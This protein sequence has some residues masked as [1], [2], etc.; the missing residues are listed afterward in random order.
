MKTALFQDLGLNENILQAIQKKGFT[1]AT[2]VQSKSIPAVLETDSDL[3]VQAQTGTGK[4]AAFGLP[5]LQLLNPSLKSVQAI[6]LTPTRELALQVSN[7]LNSFLHDKQFNIHSVYGGQSIDIQIRALKKGVDIVV[8]TPGRVID[9]IKRKTL[10]LNKINFLILDEADEMLNMGFLDDLETIMSSTPEEKRTFMFSATMP[11]AIKK[12]AESYMQESQ[13][14]K[15]EKKQLTTDLTKQIYYEVKMTYKFEALCRIIDI[16]DKFYGMVFCKTKADVDT[17][18]HHLIDRGYNAEAI[19]GDIGQIQREKTLKRFRDKI[20]NILVATDVAARGIDVNDLTHVVN[21]ALP[22]ETESYVHRIGRTGRAGKKGVAISLVSP[23]E[24]RK[25]GSIKKHTNTDIEKA[26]IPE[27]K[28]II[29]KKKQQIEDKITSNDMS[30]VHEVYYKWAVEL[31]ENYNPI[32]VL[33]STMQLGFSNALNPD[34]Y[35]EIKSSP[36]SRDKKDGRESR[37]RD[38]KGG[39]RLFIALG[40]K[41]N[42]TKIKL[43]DLL[44]SKSNVQKKYM[45]D[46]EIKDSFS[47]ITVPDNKV[48]TII[49]AFHKKRSKPLIT[50]ANETKEE[51]G[52]SR[53]K[54]K[55]KR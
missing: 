53:S 1:E 39:V 45:D 49:N 42:F 5:L 17:V 20:I 24:T 32:E 19:H 47:F 33:A 36:S 31:L 12:L 18:I 13:H 54:R 28:D 35:A 10:K 30:Q 15:I 40:K 11:S 43:L 22:Q 7:E 9:H 27:I 26:S 44:S 29:N 52:F 4:T 46:L 21:Y 6:I 14:I 38:R 2:P 25:L 51:K 23:S 16:E 34:S 41:D 50:V 55:R 8:G 48:D 37:T 3:I